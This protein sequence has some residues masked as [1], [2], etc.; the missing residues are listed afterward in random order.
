LLL[1]Q[2]NLALK[3]WG[4]CKE[5]P[6]CKVKMERENNA[7]NRWLTGEEEEKL[8]KV[9]P[10]WLKE[11]ILFALN[12]GMREREILNLG[13]KSVDLLRKVVLVLQEKTNEQKTIPLITKVV[14]LLKAKNKVRYLGQ[15]FVFSSKNGTKILGSNLVRAFR[16]ALKKAG[17]GDFRFHDLRHTIC[18]SVGPIRY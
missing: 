4:W 5:N 12:T 9:S 3:E 16:V 2:L 18:Q 6:F 1:S 13:W 17:I 7:R 15:D 11:I 10:Q 8:L 14:E